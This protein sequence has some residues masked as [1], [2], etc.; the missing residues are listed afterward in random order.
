MVMIPDA[1]VYDQ[2]SS[3]INM[4]KGTIN[5]LVSDFSSLNTYLVD[6]CFSSGTF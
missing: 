1:F 3:I 2:C 5:F 4:L 6:E